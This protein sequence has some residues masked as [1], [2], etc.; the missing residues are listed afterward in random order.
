MHFTMN[1]NGTI[2]R[3][4]EAKKNYLKMVLNLC[5]VLVP[6]HYEHDI[7]WMSFKQKITNKCRTRAA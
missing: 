6:A 3:E 5:T 7:R 1:L 2:E 4:N